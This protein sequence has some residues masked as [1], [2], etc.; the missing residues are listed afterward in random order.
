MLPDS[1]IAQSTIPISTAAPTHYVSF[2]THIFLYIFQKFFQIFWALF[3]PPGGFCPPFSNSPSHA[4]YSHIFPQLSIIFTFPSS[5][6][7]LPDDRHAPATNRSDQPTTR[8]T[9]MAKILYYTLNFNSTVY[10]SP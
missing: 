3:P 2:S 10:P 8:R 9:Y 1:I 4:P 7:P 5:G 6:Y